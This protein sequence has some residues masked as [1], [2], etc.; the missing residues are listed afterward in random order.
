MTTAATQPLAQ[1][2]AR[3]T[4]EGELCEKLENG[5]VRCFA[6]GHRCLIPPGREGVCRV[7]FN[8][9]GSLRVPFGYVAGLHLDPVEK[10]PFFHALPGAKALSFGMLGCDFHCGY[11]FTGDTIVATDQGPA[12]F[13]DLH[14]A[15]AR[16]ET[17]ENAE[18]AYP[19]DL[20]VVAASGSLRRVRGVVRHH[21][22]GDMLRI[23]AYYLPPIKCTPDHR[24]YATRGAGEPPRPT[25]ARDLTL[26][27]Y[28]AI[29][30][31][32]VAGERRTLDTAGI[33]GSHRLTRR[34]RWKL[35]AE[36][37]D[38]VAIASA[39]GESSRT[40]GLTLGKSA[41]YVRH[42]RGKISRGLGGALR[43]YGVVVERDTI[44]FPGEHA[45]GIPA[46]VVVDHDLAALL[47]YYCSEGCVVRNAGRPNSHVLNFSF[48]PRE[49][50]LAERVRLLLK[51]CLGVEAHL[52]ERETTLA[53]TVSKSSAALLFKAL[54]GGRSSEK[55]VPSVIAAAPPDVVTS[56]LDAYVEGDGH[57]YPS[58]K[59]V[60][61]TV[62][63]ALAHGIAWLVLRAGH[64]P[65]IYANAVGP[66]GLVQGRRVR[67]APVQYTMVW[68]PERGVRR[69]MLE[70]PNHYLVP[71][72]SI[73]SEAFRGDVYNLEAEGEHSYL[74]GFFEVSNCQNWLTSQALRDPGAMAPADETS[75][76]TIV[77][78]AKD[79]G[80][81]I[82]TSTYNEPLITSEW[83][84]HV[85]RLA[86]PAGLLCSYVSNGNATPEVLEYIRPWV[87]LYKVDL[88]GFRDRP[89]RDLGGTLERVLWTIRALHE[90]GFWLEVV[91]LVV[92]G[93]NDSNEELRDIARF[94]V[95]VS[96]DIP[97]HVTAFHPDYKMDD[98]DATSVRSLLRAA[99]IG[100]EEGL[101]FVYAGNLPGMVR[102][103]ENTYC[104][105]CRT[106]L[107]ERLGYRVTQ[108]R[109]DAEGRCPDCRRQIPGVWR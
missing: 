5:R 101:H 43:T 53:V 87:S 54:A 3:Y 13:A 35:P 83:A 56:F 94:L 1:L 96:P 32:V 20:R 42:V 10:K 6:C 34:I 15:C 63:R 29:P 92:P 62:S 55:R 79:R 18:L 81:R 16:K 17:R 31:R 68:Y 99:E 51:T 61:T 74:A 7:R 69:R 38:L 70:T 103:W 86:R 88:K 85:F 27:D 39:A 93:F 95:S 105:G 77:R 80:A 14:E 109:I 11:C 25:L 57:R 72:R 45:P 48:G 64:A 19:E 66:L 58:G 106:V 23:Q 104:P 47:G 37:R 30:R 21:Y 73:K 36:Q 33:L 44:R 90:R 107:V 9:Q 108:N 76:E 100:A 12:T 82:V 97:W 22:A 40:I 98:R 89:Y 50:A 26:G 78:V 41:S 4:R 49:R 8:E 24:V 52:V 71:L 60:A 91:T 2:L 28:L 102:S 75:A 46:R 84:V 67:R 59:V 65:S